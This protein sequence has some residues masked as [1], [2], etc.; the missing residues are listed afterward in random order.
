[1]E[2]LGAKIEI[3]IS[4]FMNDMNRLART[5][6]RMAETAD[7]QFKKVYNS[8]RNNL[9]NVGVVPM[10][11]SIK[12]LRS[13]VEELNAEFARLNIGGGADGMKALK[14]LDEIEKQCIKSAEQHKEVTDSEI[15]SIER[16][17][18]ATLVL[19]ENL[20]SL[21]NVSKSLSNSDNKKISEL[22]DDINK[23]LSDTKAGKLDLEAVTEQIKLMEENAKRFSAL[24]L[25]KDDKERIRM[26]NAELKIAK[27]RLKNL[28]KSNQGGEIGGGYE[29]GGNG[30]RSIA[31]SFMEA[32]RLAA[33]G[34][35]TI[36]NAIFKIAQVL[37]ASGLG[38]ILGALALYMKKFYDW[39]EKTLKQDWASFKDKVAVLTKMKT[40]EEAL[41]DKIKRTSEAIKEE[42]KAIFENINAQKQRNDLIGKADIAEQRADLVQNYLLDYANNKGYKFTPD[43]IKK[44]TG[45]YNKD[46]NLEDFYKEIIDEKGSTKNIDA[47]RK[48][49]GILSSVEGGETFTTKELNEAKREAEWAMMRSNAYKKYADAVASTESALK[50]L[51]K[52]QEDLA[53]EKESGITESIDEGSTGLGATYV[54]TKR[55]VYEANLLAYNTFKKAQESSRKEYEKINE[56]IAKRIKLEETLENI[57]NQAYYERVRNDN[58]ESISVMTIDNLGGSEWASAQTQI[59]NASNALKKFTDLR[60][61]EL[62]LIK[63]R[64]EYEKKGIDITDTEWAH[65]RKLEAEYKSI[66]QQIAYLK[67]NGVSSQEQR[68]MIK[69]LE[70]EAQTKAIQIEN[71]EYNKQTTLLRRIIDFQKECNELEGK[72]G[73]RV[74]NAKLEVEYLEKD[75][76]LM[77]KQK[78][79]SDAELHALEQK[80]KTIKK[81]RKEV[82]QLRYN[83]AINRIDFEADMEVQRLQNMQALNKLEINRNGRTDEEVQ[84]KDLEIQVQIAKERKKQAEA[85][86]D[87]AIELQKSESCSEETEKNL[88]KAVANLEKADVE[89]QEA[90]DKLNKFN[91]GLDKTIE[92]SQE[93]EDVFGEIADGLADI[94]G[95]V[96]DN[97]GENAFSN[98]T[99][100]LSSVASAIS[101]FKS[102][103]QERAENKANGNTTTNSNGEKVGKVSA[104]TKAQAYMQAAQFIADQGSKIIATQKRIKESAEEW[105]RTVENVAHEYTMLKLEEMEYRSKNVFGVDDPYEKM[106]ASAEKYG[107]AQKKTLESLQKIQSEG[108]IKVGEENKIQ[109][110]K[111]IQ[112]T[113]VGAAAGFTVGSTASPIGAAIGAAAGA[114]TGFVTGIF[115][116]REIVD[117]F[118]TLGNKFGEVFDPDTLEINKEILASYDLLD[119]KTKQLVDNYKELKET[120]DEAKEEYMEFAK[121]MF[122]DIGDALSQTLA[123]A[124]R[125]GDVYNAVGDFRDYV[126]QQM[127]N[128]IASQVYSA[129]FGDMFNGLT[130][131]LDRALDNYKTSGNLNMLSIMEGL[132][133]EASELVGQY[134]KLMMMFQEE[135]SNW[136]LFNPEETVQEALQGSISGMSEDTAGKI[137]ANFM[138]LKLTSM[139]ISDKVREINSFIGEGNAI[140][141]NSLNALKQ[142]ADNTRYCRQ[143]EDIAE[144]MRQFQISGVKAI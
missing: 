77:E 135:M 13:N 25:G 14:S 38:L 121:E 107:E 73:W 87:E 78:N 62:S 82:E 79:L 102:I 127:E 55:E 118:D 115:A 26:L 71:D 142:I 89:L 70:L 33:S 131:R 108:Q 128:L 116:E 143:L 29:K 90:E 17:S 8:F 48:Y 141:S 52:A 45:T 58:R 75:I 136:D 50:E 80:Y 32:K 69:G 46:Y 114:I 11:E 43:F 61:Y 81:L 53:N 88:Q 103:E 3:D 54:P 57:H 83:E 84:R 39:N 22:G 122:G 74:E 18:K 97:L 4:K 31:K 137:N 109:W 35:L 23:L 60:G 91:N 104:A 98:V 2:Y 110:D 139:E 66:N 37:K 86:A 111:V 24:N 94:A 1:M 133:S 95:V 101:N 96:E 30:L 85:A 20:Q 112:D 59:D 42:T 117:V 10:E 12:T 28:S 134:Q 7:A 99:Y 68:D 144:I 113:L 65:L 64:E 34:Q 19:V 140:L 36:T 5:A 123:D 132:P 6:E 15:E 40:E 129:I 76:E 27:D 93:L 49:M 124:F 63:K 119:D 92:K 106:S 56:L 100:G 130:S 125:S 138:G 21:E 41:T 44:L 51:K 126:K 72:S 47:I 120:M 105:K 16:Q 67:G 9:E